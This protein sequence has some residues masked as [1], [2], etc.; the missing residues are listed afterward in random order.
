M[1]IDLTPEQDAFVQHLVETGRYQNPAAAIHNAMDLWVVRERARLELIAAIEEGEASAEREGWIGLDS[2]EA[3][4]AL[5]EEIK[6]NGKA[7]FA[8]AG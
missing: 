5:F 6:D 1:E 2:E 7:K 8:K 4:N 3:I